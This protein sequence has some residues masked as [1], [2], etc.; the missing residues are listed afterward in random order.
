MSSRIRSGLSLS[1]IDFR[2]YGPSELFEILK[3][4]AS[5][6]FRPDTTFSNPEMNSDRF[7]FESP[8]DSNRGKN[9]CKISYFRCG[10][11]AAERSF[12]LTSPGE[13]FELA[14]DPTPEKLSLLG[15]ELRGESEPD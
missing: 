5:F 6:A 12:R 14:F 7:R 4:R 9:G 13:R 15:Q 1:E 2:G 3:D 8:E 11:G 10:P